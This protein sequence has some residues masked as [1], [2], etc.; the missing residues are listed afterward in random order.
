[1]EQY[2]YVAIKGLRYYFSAIVQAAGRYSEPRF[3]SAIAGQGEGEEDDDKGSLVE[4]TD[5]EE[6]SGGG[7]LHSQSGV[8]PAWVAIYGC[9]YSGTD[10]YYSTRL[11][12]GKKGSASNWLKFKIEWDI[13][14]W[15]STGMAMPDHTSRRERE[16]GIRND[17]PLSF[18]QNCGIATVAVSKI[19]EGSTYV[20]VQCNI[21]YTGPKRVGWHF[22]IKLTLEGRA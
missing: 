18:T 5:T 3:A 9:F 13:Y 15:M 1:M 8:D 10:G 22:K 16:I 19:A 12:F 17:L 2:H 11:S 6:V 14:N 7:C 20:K 4:V 21:A